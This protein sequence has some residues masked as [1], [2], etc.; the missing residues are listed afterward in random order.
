MAYKMTRSERIAR[1]RLI[2]HIWRMDRDLEISDHMLR[3]NVP[4][5]WH[6]ILEDFDC[7]EPKEK[8]TLYLDR[9][10]AKVFRAM[11]RGYQARINRILQSWIQ[12]RASNLM[13]VERNLVKRMGEAHAPRQDEG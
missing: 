2:Y 7:E 3:E 10:V 1:D 13:E 9:S 8:V 4:D 6:T 11:G 12:L 5:A